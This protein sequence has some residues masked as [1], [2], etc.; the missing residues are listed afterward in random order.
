MTT[1]LPTV[2]DLLG[3]PEEFEPWDER[4]WEDSWQHSWDDRAALEQE[5]RDVLADLLD[6]AQQ[7]GYGLAWV[8][9]QAETARPSRVR[10]RTPKIRRIMVAALAEYQ[11]AQA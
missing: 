4:A 7:R 6:K 11:D 10:G 2:T 1:Q 5:C 9:A 3:P 8:T